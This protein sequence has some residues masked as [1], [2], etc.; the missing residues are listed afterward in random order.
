MGLFFVG[1]RE[2]A[3]SS[4]RVLGGSKRYY[5]AAKTNRLT[6]GWTTNNL[7][8]D[9]VVKS[10]L[11]ALRGRSR[12]QA[13]NNDYMKRFVQLVRSNVVGPK[14][15][16]LQSRCVDNRGTF[17]K[18]DS[19]TIETNFAQWGRK[20]M[21]EVTKTQ[22]WNDVQRLIM[23]TLIVDGEVL[24]REV[25]NTSAYGYQLMMID[26]ALLDVN[27][28]RE[29]LSNGNHIRFSIEF[30]PLDE[31]VAYYFCT[32]SGQGSYTYG[33]QK[34][35]RVEAAQIMH[36]FLPDRVGQK[37]G[38]PAASTALLRMNQ[39]G[40]YE[41][42][43]VTAARIGASQMGFFTKSVD[44][45]GYE[46]DDKDTTDGSLIMDVEPGV[47]EQLPNGVGFTPFDPDYPHAQ[48]DAF[49][50]ACLRGISAGLGISYHTLAN[51]LSGVNYTSSRTGALEDREEWKVLQE[52]MI[53]TFHY[54]IFNHWLE[55]GLKNGS[56]TGTGGFPL[57]VE[58]KSKFAAHVWRPRRWAWVDPLKD[59]N[60]NVI[61]INNG[62]RSRGEII[63][64][65]GGDPE[66]VWAELEAERKRLVG[67]LPTVQPEPMIDPEEEEAAT[68]G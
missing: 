13:A 18:V 35:I 34:Y 29:G 10:S 36:G 50:K 38:I 48:Y 51:D 17:D 58:R 40:G 68:N 24:I 67:I 9:D 52:W 12:E 54:R 39:L 27:H 1:K 31:P 3:P 45:T 56:I 61:A 14:G 25:Y 5:S 2:Q 63:R 65:A 42:A 15:I 16:M 23:S 62:L 26:P 64:E 28:N 43:A 37:R 46:G 32:S 60:A 7:S 8:P 22:S 49:V 44:G 57:P 47:L 20:G 6:S 19:L 55:T 4:S 66:Q 53:D 33:S 59:T 21:C 30:T 11:N 41:E